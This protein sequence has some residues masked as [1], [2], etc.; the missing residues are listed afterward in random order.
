[1]KDRYRLSGAL[2]TED[3]VVPISVDDDM[4]EVDLFDFAFTEAGTETVIAICDTS[5]KA[6][7][8]MIDY[9]RKGRF[10]KGQNIATPS[11][12]V[13]SESRRK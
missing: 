7:A 2:D 11:G 8:G 3:G 6:L 13:Y 4:S 12:P 1:M 9:V 5:G 10:E